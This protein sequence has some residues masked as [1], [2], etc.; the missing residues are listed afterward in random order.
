MSDFNAANT[1]QNK[2]IQPG[3]MNIQTASGTGGLIPQANSFANDSDIQSFMDTHMARQFGTP[4]MQP[5]QG[6]FVAPRMG[7]Q[8][9]LRT[10][11]TMWGQTSTKPKKPFGNG[12]EL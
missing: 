6:G 12:F 2:G 4:G 7:Q 11:G 5:K 10:P 1:A 3:R 8:P 9:Q